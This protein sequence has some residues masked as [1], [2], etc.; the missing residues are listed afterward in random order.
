M[1]E[2]AWR[3]VYELNENIYQRQQFLSDIFSL[4]KIMNLF[5]DE[6]RTVERRDARNC[7]ERL[8]LQCE[9]HAKMF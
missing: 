3:R 7:D 4:I 6:E 5:V 8:K 9:N 2:N 1:M